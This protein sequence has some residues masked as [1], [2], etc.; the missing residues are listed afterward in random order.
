MDRRRFLTV[1]GG[2]GLS[3]GVASLGISGSAQAAGYPYFN[4]RIPDAAHTQIGLMSPQGITSFSFTPSNGWVIV[5]QTGGYYASGIPQECFDKLGQMIANGTKIHCVAFPPAGGNSW[6]I[7]GDNDMFA[8]NIPNECYTKM[9]EFYAA[10][11]QVVHVGFP[12]AGG[13]SWVVVGS[14]GGFFA[15]NI[16]DECY[17]MIRN[18]SQGGRKVTRVSFPY[19]GGW[20]VVAQDEFFAR[21]I[22]NECYQQM[23]NFQAGGWQLHNVAFSPVSSGWSLISRG[24]VPALPVDKIRQIEANVGGKDIWS[25]MAD[26][27]TP[28]V[29]LAVVLNNQIAWST[30]YGWLE[31]GQPVATHPESAFQ[32]ASISKA[33]STIGFLKF[34]S[35]SRVIGLNSD[36]RPLL[37]WQLTKRACVVANSGPTIDQL[38][39]HRGGVIGNG[40]TS[41]ANVC[42][43]FT[44]N[45][46]GGFGGYGP[47]ATVPTL[48]E[49]LNGQGNSPKIELSTEP[50]A[51]YYYSGHGFE[52]LHRMLEV[53]TGQTLATYMQNNVFAS[54]GMNTSSYSLTPPF[55]LAAGHTTAGAVIPGKRNRYPE[56]A[57]AGLYT[58]VLDLCRMIKWVNA[59]FTSPAELGGPLNKA[60]V[61]TLLTQGATPN[62]G[63]GVFTANVGTNNFSYAHNGSNYGFKTIFTGYPNLGTGFAIMCN[64]DDYNLINDITNSVKAIYGWS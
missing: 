15:R 49:I 44:P 40:S 16:D 43:G 5:T 50:G 54:L 35:G 3:T 30:G 12:P 60:W 26:Y 53:Q 10:G 61:T 28:G 62:M 56:S 51:A 21:N 46:G 14:A 22:D 31:S 13:N 4:R 47:N 24:Q 57:A 42:S 59:A 52:L 48:L 41:P 11:Q 27:K 25:R 45:V 23:K 18:L 9:Q 36:I 8:R 7:A 6:V 32:A 33:V 37:N 58:N 64:G 63:R 19:G 2:I 20:T 38:L 39:G 17:Q 55:Q 1:T 29:A 34:L